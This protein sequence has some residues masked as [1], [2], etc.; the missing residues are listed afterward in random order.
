MIR[1]PTTTTCND[2]EHTSIRGSFKTNPTTQSWPQPQ[3]KKMMKST[4][5]Q[6]MMDAKCE[7]A[8]NVIGSRSLGP[9]VKA[10]AA[11]NMNA[12]GGGDRHHLLA[13]AH[14]SS[15]IAGESCKRQ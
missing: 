1:P 6:S 10:A 14:V 2:F 15:D 13:H 12:D 11:A 3:L 7:C 4:N 9:Y 5:D 8:N